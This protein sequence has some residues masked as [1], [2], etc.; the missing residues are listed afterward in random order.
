MMDENIW[1]EHDSVEERDGSQKTRSL[2]LPKSPS[3][4]RILASV[5]E[6]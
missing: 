5:T 3:S 1:P 4:S 6:R 2:T